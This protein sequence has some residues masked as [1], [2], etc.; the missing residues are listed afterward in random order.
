QRGSISFS[1]QRGINGNVMVDGTDYNNPFF[2]GTRGGERSGYVFTI[3]QSSIQEFQV[4]TTGYNAEYGRSTGGILNAVSKSGT[5]DYHGEA[6][7][8]TRHKELAKEPQY[9]VRTLETLQQFGGGVGGPIKKDRLLWFAAVDRQTSHLPR[10]VLFPNLDAF[11]PNA[12]QQE[13][14]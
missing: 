3:P 11:T 10:Q 4:V 13:A 7:Y 5:N 2:G 6:F 12:S 1:G 8:E 14:Y 9:H